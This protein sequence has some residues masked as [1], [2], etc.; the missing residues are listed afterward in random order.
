M[1]TSLGL[2]HKLS[3]GRLIT[4]SGLSLDFRGEAKAWKG[5]GSQ[6]LHVTLKTVRLSELI[7]SV[8][9]NGEKVSKGALHE[10][11]QGDFQGAT[12]R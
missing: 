8:C 2:I 5:P 7:Q 6:R 9:A 11:S 12:S 4:H 1:C 10:A 3:V